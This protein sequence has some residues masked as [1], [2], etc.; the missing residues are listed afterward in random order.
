M[1]ASKFPTLNLERLRMTTENP[2]VR[3]AKLRGREFDRRFSLY[4]S[5]SGQFSS[6]GVRLDRPR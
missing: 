5:S 3:N 4:S 2:D 6:V 1:A